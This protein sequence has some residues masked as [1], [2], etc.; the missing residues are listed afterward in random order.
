MMCFVMPDLTGTGA[1]TKR[2]L[3]VEDEALLAEEVQQPERSARAGD[4]VPTASDLPRLRDALER[5]DAILAEPAEKLLAR[6]RG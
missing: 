1:R 5:L 2:I 4:V 3:L 6:A